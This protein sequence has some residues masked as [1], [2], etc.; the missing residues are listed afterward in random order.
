MAALFEL[1]SVTF[2]YDGVTALQNLTMTIEPGQRLALLGA[3]GSGKSTLLKLLDGLQFAGAGKLSF[4]GETL[5]ED[6]FAKDEFQ[7]SFRKRVGFVFQNPDVQ[8]FSPSVQDEL[9]FG[10]IQLRLPLDEMRRRVSD[11]MDLFEISHL[12]DRP[13]HHLSGGEKKKVALASVLV[14][15]PEVVLLDEPTSGLDPR[16]QTNLIN[17][18][19]KWDDG[20]KTIITAT[21]DLHML[22][23]LASQCAILERG[24]LIAQGPTAQ[25]LDDRD[26]LERANLIHAHR[27]SRHPAMHSHQHLHS[28]DPHI[29]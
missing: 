21:H 8:L 5:T 24:R 18:L 23:D 10:P 15:Q 14:M 1:E 12:A 22:E 2:A 3:N 25:I 16:S 20:S 19:G 13:P 7:F 11:A 27:S 26:L 29:H 17:L 6:R 9:E 28:S 4:C